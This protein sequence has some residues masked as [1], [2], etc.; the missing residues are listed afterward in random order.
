LYVLFQ[1]LRRKDQLLQE[2]NKGE[3]F[4]GYTEGALKFK[5]T[6]KYDVGS[7]IYDTSHKLSL[8]RHHVQDATF[9]DMS[10]YIGKFYSLLQIYK[11]TLMDDRVLFKVDHSS[12]LDALLT[13]YESLECFISSDHKPVKAH[14]CLK[15]RSADD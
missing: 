12:G 4:N 13:S 5:S 14:L 1:N 7:S 9:V 15:V 10:Q 3:L 2:S 6:Y 8:N 11:S